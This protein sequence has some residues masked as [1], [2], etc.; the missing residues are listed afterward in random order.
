DGAGV[1]GGAP[2]G[3]VYGV[4]DTEGA[5]T[6]TGLLAGAGRGPAGRERSAGDAGRGA[7]GGVPLLLAGR[8]WRAGRGGPRLPRSR[9][10]V[11]GSS[12][13]CGGRGA[14]QAFGRRRHGVLDRGIPAAGPEDGSAAGD[15][16][17]LAAAVL[18]SAGPD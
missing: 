11:R 12:C 10:P 7:A 1:S 14:G 3:R 9:P 16:A 4:P 2:G 8:A 17:A 5:G 13:R 15:R 6:A 18:A